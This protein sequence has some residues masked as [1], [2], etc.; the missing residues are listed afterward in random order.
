MRPHPDQK[1]GCV[2]YAQHGDDIMLLNLLTLLDIKPSGLPLDYLDLGA[3]HPSTISNTKLLYE[4]GYRGVNIEA[5]PELIEPFNRERP[6]D[7]T[8]NV[9]VG[10]LPSQ[11]KA[12]FYM[13]SDTSGRNTFSA[14][15]VQS[16]KG[17]M[18][19]RKEIELEVKTLDQII[20]QYCGGSYP[21]IL[22]CDIEGLDYEVLKSADFDMFS[23][24]I[25]CVETRR[26]QTRK[27]STMLSEKMPEGYERYCRMGENM[28]F[29]RRDYF[30]LAF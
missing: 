17:I 12:V 10:V 4:R 2:T 27:M 15:E 24:I 6:L 3:H 30:G 11:T 20:K 5:N 7:L 18:T 1:Y 19:V 25:I 8:V 23:P 28:F 16:L 21:P 14:D 29:I 9:G 13:Y 22:L 26:A